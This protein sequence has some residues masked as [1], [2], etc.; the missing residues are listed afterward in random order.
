[1]CELAAGLAERMIRSGTRKR[2]EK[3]VSH[4]VVGL[5]FSLSSVA[6]SA[7]NLHLEMLPGSEGVGPKIEAQLIRVISARPASFIPRTRHLLDDGSPR[8]T[9]R[10]ALEASPYLQQHAHNPVNWYPWGEEAFESAK[11]LGRPV[12]V[13]IGY[14][15]CHWCHVMEE[16]SF[17]DFQVAEFLN[18]HF[19]A[20]KVDRE[21]RPDI[22]KV[23]MT[24]VQ[25]MGSN[26]GWPLN[27]W[28]T[29]DRKPFFG[30]TYFPPENR[31]NRPGFKTV[32]A[33]LQSAW[34][35][36]REKIMVSSNQISVAVIAAIE[37]VGANDGRFPDASILS[38]AMTEVNA[39]TDP[40][41]GGI[42]LHTK[43]PSSMPL[44]FLLRY[45][46]R[47]GDRE[48][49]RLALLTLKKM[50]YGGIF[51]HLG[52][53][54]H[55]YSTERSWQIPHFE[56][57]LYDN[58]LLV[59]IYLEAGQVTGRDELLQVARDTLDYVATEM[60]SDDGGFYS[61][62]DADSRT[63]SGE[64]KEGWFYTW[65]PAD[66]IE[67]LGEERARIFSAYFGVHSEGGNEGRIIIKKVRS[68]RQ[69]AEFLGMSQAVLRSE[70]TKIRHDLRLVRSGRTPPL[71]DEKIL[72]AWNGLM[73]SAFARGGFVLNSPRY[74]SYARRA[75]EFLLLRVRAKG[76]LSRV[77]FAG[78]SSGPG[79]LADYAF[80]IAGL[81]DLF[82]AD[83]NLRWLNAA[84]ELQDI[85]NSEYGD[86]EGGAYF[87]VPRGVDALFTR[88]KIGSDGAL[89]SGNSVTALN[90]L[91]LYE[92]TLN[93]DYQERANQIFQTFSNAMRRHPLAFS[94]LLVALDYRLDTPFEIILVAP[95][96][97]NGLS[98][99]LAP[100][101]RNFVPNRVL[102]IAQEGDDFAQKAVDIPIIK[103]RK[104]LD[105][106]ATAYVCVN[107][108]C[109]FPTTDAAQLEQ[110]IT[111]VNELLH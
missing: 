104:V 111:Q 63:P 7:A 33:F 110:Q 88:Q 3:K 80:L 4:W 30:G 89:P 11:A 24:A 58:A 72:T 14:S 93:A 51:D 31:G 78:E 60:T 5:C 92:Y 65:A 27:V 85:V 22:D 26:G 101:R 36:Q 44:R 109:R 81:L 45:H 18:K 100:I 97:G 48:A 23:Y 79:F 96:T 10:L 49:L 95:S 108:V 84:I 38:Q 32:L 13:S 15:T 57:M 71:R 8:F 70:I 106:T 41:W 42:G 6:C 62:L 9:N 34:E 67:S 37:D 21:I 87:R 12:L 28:V 25:A 68:Q 61:A 16:E 59:P 54:F 19:I 43:F 53:G 90:L 66:L 76:R 103:H 55:R 77:F 99:L 39:Q 107:Q 74:L 52:G 35:T 98:E 20:I 83:P 69:A 102:A 2:A 75:A 56:K 105:D 47:T 86:E 64:M 29:P 1:M 46:R 17:D 91:R 73:I 94:D 82:E 40:V 50:A